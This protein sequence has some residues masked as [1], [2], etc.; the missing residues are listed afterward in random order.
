[1]SELLNRRNVLH[2]VVET[3]MPI[4]DV[5]RDGVAVIGITGRMEAVK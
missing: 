3:K 5:E 4:S 1:M 2:Q